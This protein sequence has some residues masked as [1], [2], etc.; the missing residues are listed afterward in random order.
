MGTGAVYARSKGIEGGFALGD[1]TGLT[2]D[3]VCREWKSG[4]LKVLGMPDSLLIGTCG[5]NKSSSSWMAAAPLWDD[6]PWR[7]CRAVKERESGGA[8]SDRI[9]TACRRCRRTGVDSWWP[10]GTVVCSPGRSISRETWRTLGLQPAASRSMPGR[11]KTLGPT[12][13]ERDL[14]EPR[15]DDRPPC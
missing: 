2:S 10:R 6:V 11:A 5:R 8:A 3:S 12:K 15:Q 9:S 4:K 13:V 14:F 1:V 7:R